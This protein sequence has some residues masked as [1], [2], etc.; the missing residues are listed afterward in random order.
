MF[1]SAQN[2]QYSAPHV[3]AYPSVRERLPRLRELPAPPCA[4]TCVGMFTSLLLPAT[5]AWRPYMGTCNMQQ[6]KC[7]AAKVTSYKLDVAS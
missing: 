6:G 4:S 5:C 2:L 7:G 1:T 3:S